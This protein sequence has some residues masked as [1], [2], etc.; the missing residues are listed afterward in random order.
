[1]FGRGSRLGVAVSGGA[2]SVCLLHIL[3]MLA[4]EWNLRLT[5]LHLDH[6]LRGEESRR[7]AEFVRELARKLGLPAIAGTANLAVTTDNLEQAAR[8][9]RLA[10]FR[11]AIQGSEV[12][13]VA[14]GHTRSD[15]AETVLFRMLRGS[16]SAGL[17]GIRPVTSDGLVRPLLGIERVDVEQFLRER[18]LPGARIPATPARS[19]PA[20]ASATNCFRNSPAIGTRPSRILWP[21]PPIGRRPRK[22]IGIQKSLS[23]PPPISR[24]RLAAFSC[25]STRFIRC[26]WPP[27]AVWCGAPWKR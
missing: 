3:H 7:D 13:R 1:M 20:T 11:E 5:V 21:T 12:E 2:D 18:G 25:T 4:P 27:P 10:F 6:G 17:S 23:W 26:P 8:E 9:A 19:L 16:G 15:Q 24:K 14:T 22:P